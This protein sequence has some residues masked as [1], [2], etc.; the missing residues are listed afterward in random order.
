MKMKFALRLPSLVF[1]L[2]CKSIYSH[3]DC[4]LCNICFALMATSCE[5]LGH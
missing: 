2:H 3:S 5:G 1:T 4:E